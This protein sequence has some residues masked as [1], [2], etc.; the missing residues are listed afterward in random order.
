MKLST[1]LNK[2]REKEMKDLQYTVKN[3][4]GIH[5]R[6]AALL[7]QACTNFK[8][9]VMI[10]CNGNVASGNNVLQILALHAAKGSVLNITAD[11]PDEEEAIAKIQEVL[12]E[13]AIILQWGLMAS[14]LWMDPALL[15]MIPYKMIFII[16]MSF[17]AR[18]ARMVK[19]ALCLVFTTSETRRIGNDSVIAN[20]R[21]LITRL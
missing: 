7:A 18:K 13:S 19:F 6:P 20:S 5:A 12:K 3:S 14:Y 2:R 15:A 1:K 17:R 10:E 11:G 8:S 16:A 9:A 21:C 4:L